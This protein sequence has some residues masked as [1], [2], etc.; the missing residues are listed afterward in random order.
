M[1]SKLDLPVKLNAKL[2]A[3]R[4]LRRRGILWHIL[5]LIQFCSWSSAINYYY[6]CYIMGPENRSLHSI[7][8]DNR[9]L[10]ARLIS[11][12]GGRGLALQR[13]FSTDHVTQEKSLRLAE[14]VALHKNGNEGREADMEVIFNPVFYGGVGLRFRNANNSDNIPE[15]CYFTSAQNLREIIASSKR[16]DR[17][18]QIKKKKA[19]EAAA[20]KTEE[21]IEKEREAKLKAL[22]DKM[23]D[24][25]S[26]RGCHFGIGKAFANS[27]YEERLVK[28]TSSN[29]TK[30]ML[31]RLE[32]LQ[33]LAAIATANDQSKQGFSGKVVSSYIKGLSKFN[34]SYPIMTR[35]ADLAEN[36]YERHCLCTYFPFYVG[37]FPN[38]K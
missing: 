3:R 31:D 8:D 33:L 9:R 12:Y 30:A 15:K 16:I 22:L 17:K 26:D 29:L 19:E 20:K 4:L 7:P 25:K 6:R 10:K 28:A 18:K 27:K 32:V 36:N 13:L 37:F 34:K 2:S 11:A 21:Q 1:G 5:L 35:T 24:D 14:Q 38:K 23:E